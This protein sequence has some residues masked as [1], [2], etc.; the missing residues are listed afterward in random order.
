[1]I[2]ATSSYE[3]EQKLYFICFSSPSNK[4]YIEFMQL[5][6]GFLC[7]F[8]ICS[9]FLQIKLIIIIAQGTEMSCDEWQTPKVSTRVLEV[10]NY[11]K[12]Q[13]GEMCIFWLEGPSLQ[14]LEKRLHEVWPIFSS[15][16]W[17]FACSLDNLLQIVWS[18]A[19]LMFG[20]LF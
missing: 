20:P 3:A 1:M 11:M 6:F 16:S 19:V 8:K 17:K 9:C 7:W 12:L 4:Y 14:N 18:S 10:W 13:V 5:L 15:A 2:I